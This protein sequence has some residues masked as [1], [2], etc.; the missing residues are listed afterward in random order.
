MPSRGPPNTTLTG[1]VANH[2]AR[3]SL[4]GPHI[5]GRCPDPDWESHI[6]VRPNNHKPAVHNDPTASKRQESTKKLAKAKAT[7]EREQTK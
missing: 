4:E 6:P 1:P 5:P 2:V 3:W 7:D